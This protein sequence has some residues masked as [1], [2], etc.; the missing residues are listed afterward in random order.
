[1]QTS[2]RT[3]KH[4]KSKSYQGDSVHQT[5]EWPVFR[6]FCFAFQRISFSGFTSPQGAANSDSPCPWKA[7]EK[8]LA[9]P[10]RHLMGF[11]G[12]IPPLLGA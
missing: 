12:R 5:D 6:G 11:G 8:R 1:M 10:H 2:K 9:S 7:D 3:K 4:E